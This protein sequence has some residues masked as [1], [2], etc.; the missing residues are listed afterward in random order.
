MGGA[1]PSTKD[2]SYWHAGKHHWATPKDLSR[3]GSPVLLDTDRKIT[4]AGVKHISSGLLPIGT[5]LLSSRAPIGYLAIAEVP[6]AINQG[7]VAMVCNGRLPNVYVLFWC[8]EN[9][10]RIKS[11]SGGSTFAEI[12]K[13][14]FRSVPITVPSGDI[15]EAYNDLVRPLYN[16]IAV[17]MRESVLLAQ[18]RDLLLPALMSGEI[19]LPEE[20]RRRL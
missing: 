11:L 13:K 8:Y 12:S 19:C 9:L 6:T 4:E 2:S 3:L 20:K 16:R 17:N 1:T 7:F 10:E 18:T 5:V 15:L 14:T